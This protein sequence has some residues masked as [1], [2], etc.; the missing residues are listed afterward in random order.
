M[1][2]VGEEIWEAKVPYNHP[3]SL[4]TNVPERIYVL[5]FYTNDRPDA[6]FCVFFVVVFMLML[7]P[8]SVEGV[9][10]MIQTTR[11][12]RISLCNIIII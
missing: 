9:L 1:F 4:Y 8:S 10:C 5:L 11:G 12:K 2:G 6:C 3:C 7:Y